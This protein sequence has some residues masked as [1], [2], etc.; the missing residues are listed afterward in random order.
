MI[1]L[2]YI[3]IFLV[4][5]TKDTYAYL[6]PGSGN[7][8]LQIIVAFF[9]SIFIS[10]KIFWTKIT[11]Y[12]YKLVG[13]KRNKTKRKLQAPKPSYYRQCAQHHSQQGC[14]P[15]EDRGTHRRRHQS[16]QPSE[17]RRHCARECN[18]SSYSG[19]HGLTRGRGRINYVKIY[20]RY[21]PK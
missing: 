9:A 12:Y 16:Q 10:L 17:R 20:Q 14:C 13:K 15:Q 2:I 1:L 3:L 8:I 4:F 7:Y 21:N 6:D 11:F 19:G 5:F 18:R